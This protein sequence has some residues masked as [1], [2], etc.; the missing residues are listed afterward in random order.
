MESPEYLYHYTNVRALAMILK[1]KS[2]KFNP[3]TVMDDS[4]EEFIKDPQ[5]FGK[6]CF[7]SSWTDDPKESIPMW[8][9]YTNMIEGVRIKLP[10]Y[11]F[12]QYL[13]DASVARLGFGEGHH[14][15]GSDYYIVP[16]E[17]YF[18]SD[19]F[20]GV[21][22]QKNLLHQ[23]TYTDDDK[24]LCPQILSV[25]NGNTHLDMGTL[26]RYKNTHWD[27]QSEWRY[28]LHFMPFGFREMYVDAVLSE[29][30]NQ[31]NLMKL[32]KGVD[33]PFG[34]YFLSFDDDKFLDMEITLS[35]RIDAGNK[36]LVDLL[37]EKFNPSAE[38]VESVL[39]NRLR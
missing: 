34:A 32:H 19:Y 38:V 16:G 4:E 15:T 26:G 7:V 20:V 2:L 27:F 9:M 17:E 22:W 14:I 25:K 31:A 21:P 28:I 6:Y 8:N 23:V 18:T 24:L 10:R 30:P 33:L 1:N 39:T 11:P 35:P 29:K 13:I 5:G 36:I 3:L 12:K 37:V